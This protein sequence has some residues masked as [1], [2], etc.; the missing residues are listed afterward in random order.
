M[1]SLPR[2]QFLAALF[3]LDEQ[4]N[5]PDRHDFYQMQ[6]TLAVIGSKSKDAAKRISYEKL[7]IPFVAK[8]SGP[9]SKEGAASISKAIWGAR[10]SIAMEGQRKEAER[11]ER[12]GKHS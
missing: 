12:I 8:E 4:W 3:W 6:N 10:L 5:R 1:Q 2:R 11:K 9:Q 7:R